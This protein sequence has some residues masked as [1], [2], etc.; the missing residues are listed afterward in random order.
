LDAIATQFVAASKDARKK[1]LDEASAIAS[2]AGAAGKHYIRAMEK[3]LTGTEGYI[4]KEA[5]R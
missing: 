3:V 1:L 5:K 4:E 2:K